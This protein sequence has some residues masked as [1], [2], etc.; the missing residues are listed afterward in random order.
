MEIPRQMIIIIIVIITRRFEKFLPV[1]SSSR[2][3][4]FIVFFAV[5]VVHE[6]CNF[7]V[8]S[9]VDD[10]STRCH[11]HTY[12]GNDQ[13]QPYIF[14]KMLFYVEHDIAISVS[15][16]RFRCGECAVVCVFAKNGKLCCTKTQNH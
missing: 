4:S 1:F 10:N 2:R 5:E 12:Y 15:V 13:R 7:V 8:F 16:M 6:K 11:M 9:R 14:D 3:S